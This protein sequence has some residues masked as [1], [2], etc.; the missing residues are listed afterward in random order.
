MLAKAAESGDQP[1]TAALLDQNDKQTA[2]FCKV[3]RTPRLARAVPQAFLAGRRWLLRPQLR[4]RT[5]TH[6]RCKPS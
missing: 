6:Q 4:Q 3:C 2:R 5:T 1:L